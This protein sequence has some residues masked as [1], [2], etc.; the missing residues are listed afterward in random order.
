MSTMHKCWSLYNRVEKLRVDDLTRDQ[1]RTILLSIPTN[2][3]DE[4]FAC[5]E[6]DLH[7]QPIREFAEFYEDAAMVKGEFQ[8]VAGDETPPEVTA[9]KTK[10]G[11][12][13]TALKSV[14]T[15]TKPEER[16]PLF[17]DVSSD[18]FGTGSTL[19]VESMPTRERRS[20]RR[21]V[22]NLVFQAKVNGVRFE[23]E[24]RDISMAGL[25]LSKN[26]PSA[27][28]K[29][30]K[31]ELHLNGGVIKIRVVKVSPMSL[32]LKDADAWDLLR[33]WIVSW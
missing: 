32:R 24:T 3:M 17:E 19:K 8:A 30:F 26:L 9:T 15:G 5:R 2:R 11:T 4:W 20:A 31:A 16:R 7:W 21:Y 14:G 6:G 10:N 33:Q 27:F 23:C 13:N 25:S 29:E 18:L 28:G 12:K 22:R 1:V